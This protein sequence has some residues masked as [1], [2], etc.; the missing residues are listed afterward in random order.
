MQR[1]K[2]E[3]GEQGKEGGVYA[4]QGELLD[5]RIKDDS[6]GLHSPRL[7]SGSGGRSMNAP[8]KSGLV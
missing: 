7:S 2:R 5:G 8:A 4:G 6:T 1:A 3:E